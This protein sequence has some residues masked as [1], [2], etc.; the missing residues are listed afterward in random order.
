MV[1]KVPSARKQ[2]QLLALLLLN[3]NQV[4]PVTECIEELW[5]QNPPAS[6]LS[7]LQ[8]YVMQLRKAFRG[9]KRIDSM[10]MRSLLVTKDRGYLF[11]VRDGELDLHVFESCARE[12][13]VALSNGKLVDAAALFRRA[14]GLWR[15]PAL[16][17]VEP[18]PMLRSWLNG[19]EEY[20]LSTLE[21]RIEADLGLGKHHE[22]LSEL[23]LLVGQQPLHESLHAQFMVAL[24]RSGRPAHALEV[25]HRLRR[26]LDDELGLDPSPRMRRLQQAILSADPALEVS[27]HAGSRLSLDL[28]D[29]SGTTRQDRGQGP[30]R[31]SA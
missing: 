13:R 14:L 2:R 11:K 12:G 16:V 28:V 23:S 17:D 7:T 18:G 30:A 19:I 27:A 4:V 8:T 3:S 31:S 25:Y 21:Q 24:Y 26:A 1:S 9:S 6:A 5:G 15:G 20:R 10:S 22:L 29:R